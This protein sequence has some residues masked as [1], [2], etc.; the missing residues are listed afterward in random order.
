MTISMESVKDVYRKN[1]MHNMNINK[2]KMLLFHGTSKAYKGWHR[3][4][5]VEVEWKMEGSVK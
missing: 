3:V 2:Q 5:K 4:S 1:D